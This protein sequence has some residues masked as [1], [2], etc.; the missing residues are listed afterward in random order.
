MNIVI[1]AEST[2]TDRYQTTVPEAVRRA[3]K[4]KKRDKIHYA[5]I[6]GKV[7]IEKLDPGTGRDPALEPFLDL[8]AQDLRGH[9]ERILPLGANLSDRIGAL[10]DGVEIDIDS[11][12]PEEDE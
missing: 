4:L 8:L 12:L 2:L 10:V 7:V 9:P 1:E 11:P 5:F 6:D 3:L